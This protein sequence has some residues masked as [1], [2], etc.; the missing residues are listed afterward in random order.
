MAARYEQ[1]AVILMIQR[2]GYFGHAFGRTALYDQAGVI[3]CG[4]FRMTADADD[5]VEVRKWLSISRAVAAVALQLLGP[6]WS[7]PANPKA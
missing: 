2:D 7:G 6:S 5:G 1:W 4:E 3:A